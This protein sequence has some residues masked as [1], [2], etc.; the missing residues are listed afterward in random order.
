M[1]EQHTICV[2]YVL[3]VYKEQVIGSKEA[4]VSETK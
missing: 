4:M 3:V 1:S 2:C